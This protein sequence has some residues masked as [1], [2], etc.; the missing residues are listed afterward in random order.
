LEGPFQ[1]ILLLVF[2]LP[3]LFVAFSLH[4]SDERQSLPL[5]DRGVATLAIAAAASGQPTMALA[6]G[7]V[8]LT[9]G[10]FLSLARSAHGW[11]WPVV[12]TSA[13]L[14]SAFPF[15]ATNP[16]S[17]MPIVFFVFLIAYAA[18]IAGWMRFAFPAATQ[19]AASEPWMRVVDI[20][21]LLLIPLLFVLLNLGLAPNP[22][23]STEVAW[24]P[25]IIVIALT[26]ITFL[27][28]QR[29]M[30]FTFIPPFLISLA[31]SIASMNWL[32]VAF[33]WMLDSLRWVL[34]ILS[35][36]LEGQAGVL[37]A[38]LLIVLLLSLASQLALGV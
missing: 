16:D 11:R 34:R 23:N 19:P 27:I 20:L 8:L 1:I 36:V 7:M 9:S 32:Q 24:I 22:S 33:D 3:V 26:G 29:S 13:V 6:F 25:A 2:L 31:A 37:W 12:A 28:A 21:G 30:R 10:S 38:M 18:L 14:F 17:N 5:F 35:R 4:Q 15:L